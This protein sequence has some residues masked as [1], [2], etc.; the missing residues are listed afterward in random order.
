MDYASKGVGTAALTTG[1]IGTAGWAIELLRNGGLGNLLGGNCGCN[2]GAAMVSAMAPAIAA[3]LSGG[4]GGCSENT[5]VTRYEQTLALSNAAKDSE[6]SLLKA[7]KYT[8]Q[9]I[10]EVFTVLDGKISA[11]RDQQNATNLQQAT[12]NATNTATI[13]CMQGQIAQLL[14]LTKLV[15]P[16]GSVCPGWG[17]VNVTPATPSAS[18]TA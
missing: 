3:A 2:G 14:G 1:I 6:I 13:A 11:L 10:T 15:V 18:A 16:N 9:K 17:N 12:Y 5:P 4:N 7:D 8:D